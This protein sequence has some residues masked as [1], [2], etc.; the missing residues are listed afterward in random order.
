MLKA[1][2]AIVCT[3]TC[4][5]GVYAQDMDI[6]SSYFFT[7]GSRTGKLISRSHAAYT[8]LNYD[9]DYYLSLAYDDL[10][11]NNAQW[12]YKQR[13]GLAAFTYRD[14][15]SYYK[16]GYAYFKGNFNLYS[17]PSVDLT[18]YKY[19]DYSNLYFGDYTVKENSWFYGMGFSYLNVTGI[20]TQDSVRAQKVGQVNLRLEKIISASLFGSIKP[21]YVTLKDGRKF[22]SCALK[23][24]YV[25]FYP[26]IIKLGGSIGN[27]AYNFDSDL[28][29]IFNQYETQKTNYFIQTEY[30]FGSSFTFVTSYQHARF[31]PYNQPQM[32][33]YSMDYYIAGIK[34]KF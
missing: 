10:Y 7:Y 34:A 33:A 12:N 17:I 6:S 5:V 15:D 31:E 8:T 26:L 30:G 32:S 18:V 16:L 28:F 27:R 4:V 25:P 11:E 13:M 29:T 3:L 19:S 2:F 22:V 1:V 23:V 24:H 21:A 14:E 20:L 9:S